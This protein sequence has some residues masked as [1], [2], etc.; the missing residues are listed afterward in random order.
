MVI[1]HPAPKMEWLNTL[2]AICSEVPTLSQENA[3]LY[4]S[5]R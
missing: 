3:E 2:E 1:F 4:N 5:R